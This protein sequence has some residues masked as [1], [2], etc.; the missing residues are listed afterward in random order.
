[1]TTKA[2]TP[3]KSDLVNFSDLE[4]LQIT[5]EI[6]LHPGPVSEKDRQALDAI[7]QEFIRRDSLSYL[8]PSR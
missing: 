7:N 6:L 4:L 1:M 2:A 3:P 8:P 5:T